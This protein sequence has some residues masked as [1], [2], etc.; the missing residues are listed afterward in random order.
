MAPDD[1]RTARRRRQ[2]PGELGGGREPVGGRPGKGAGDRLLQNLRHVVPERAQARHRV[3]QALGGDRL[4]R[5]TE[6][7]R[8]TRQHLVEHAAQ[9]VDVAPRVH[10]PGG[11]LLGA[12]VLRGAHR[13]AGLGELV[14]PAS[15]QRL[16]NAEV[17]H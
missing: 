11:R 13:H 2:C 12:H 14:G 10:R 4:G 7:G 1:T 8:L 15:F 16:G 17:G 9:A 6:V 3:Q 5:V